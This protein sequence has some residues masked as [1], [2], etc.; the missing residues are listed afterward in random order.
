MVDVAL[1]FGRILLL[2]LL[3]LFLWAAVRTGMGLVRSGAPGKGERALAV[4]V[5]AGPPELKGIKVALERP[6]RIGRAPGLELVIADDFVSTRHA[7][8]VPAPGGPVLEDLGSTNGTLVNGSRVRAPVRLSA[9][10]VVEI[11]TVTL[12][13]ARL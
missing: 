11:G 12:K 4:V 9:G 13:V 10:D 2:A 7:Q 5:T 6:V 8:I 3:Y 1:L